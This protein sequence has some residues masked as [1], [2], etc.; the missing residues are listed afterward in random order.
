M[1]L[2]H[3][4]IV[5]ASGLL[6]G[7]YAHATAQESPSRP[8][9]KSGSAQQAGIPQLPSPTGQFG[10]GRVGYEWTDG[11]RPDD[12]MINMVFVDRS[13]WSFGNGE[14]WN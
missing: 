5:L 9:L 14:P 12:I 7:A 6:V 13:D 1:S 8:E 2:R 4:T 11:S 10:V 3:A